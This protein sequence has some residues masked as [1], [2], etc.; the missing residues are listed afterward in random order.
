MSIENYP[1]S[2]RCSLVSFLL[3]FFIIA[4]IS[5]S[6]QIFDFLLNDAKEADLSP[7]RTLMSHHGTTQGK[8]AYYSNNSS[9]KLSLCRGNIHRF[10]RWEIEDKTNNNNSTLRSFLCCGWDPFKLGN[11]TSSYGNDEKVC[12]TGSRVNGHGPGQCTFFKQGNNQKYFRAGGHSCKCEQK[13]GLN[14]KSPREM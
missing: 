12:D 3:Y 4:F 10:G 11:D 6:V 1:I 2:F 9:E 5:L 13:Y 14:K 8:S 7:G